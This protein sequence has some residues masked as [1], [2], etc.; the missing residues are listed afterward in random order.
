M[1]GPSERAH[2]RIQYP[3]AA[4]PHLVID[5]DSREVIDLSEGGVRFR[6]EEAMSFSIGAVVAGTVRFRRTEPVVVKGTVVRVA[7][8]EV[9]VKF[10]LGVPLRTIIEEQRFLREHHRGMA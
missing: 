8:R 7:G 3:P 9:A 10:E 6:V 4:R 5:A 2:H 1:T